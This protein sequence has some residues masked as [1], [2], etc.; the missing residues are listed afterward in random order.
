[1]YSIEVDQVIMSCDVNFDESALGISE[2]ISKVPQSISSESVDDSLDDN[3]GCLR[4]TVYKHSGK[5]QHRPSGDDGAA[6]KS[7][8]L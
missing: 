6:R 8:A 4:Y 1:M 3:D 7:R 5:L 2:S